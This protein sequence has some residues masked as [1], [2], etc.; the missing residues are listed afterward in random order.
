VPSRRVCLFRLRRADHHNR[1]SLVG[2]VSVRSSPL[3][4]SRA[5][6]R[7]STFRSTSASW[8][9]RLSH[10][11]FGNEMTAD[12]K[13]ATE[14]LFST[15]SNHHWLS[16]LRRGYR[17]TCFTGDL[18]AMRAREASC[19]SSM[20]M[21]YY[22]TEMRSACLRSVLCSLPNRLQAM[23]GRTDDVE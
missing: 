23:G 12:T 22:Q 18:P 4:H 2:L 7:S 1:A 11:N 14:H 3:H 16:G 5:V 17:T 10:E 19:F 15:G 6:L 21:L 20:Q 8:I 9:S 13:Y